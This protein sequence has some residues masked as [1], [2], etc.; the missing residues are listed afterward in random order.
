MYIGERWTQI[1]M[2]GDISVSFTQELD[3]IETDCIDIWLCVCFNEDGN[4]FGREFEVKVNL[5]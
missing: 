4:Y 5:P 1:R 3:E 2:L